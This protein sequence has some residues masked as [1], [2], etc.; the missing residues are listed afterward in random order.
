MRSRPSSQF[1]DILPGSGETE[2]GAGCAT[3]PGHRANKSTT[4]KHPLLAEGNLSN[5]SFLLLFPAIE[6]SCRA[7]ALLVRQPGNRAQVASER[8]QEI[9]NCLLVFCRKLVEAMDH[10]IRF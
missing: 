2:M 5:I 3:T 9:Q 4:T 6:V 10:L 1:R 8:S 7:D